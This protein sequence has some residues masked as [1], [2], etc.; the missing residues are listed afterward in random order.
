MYLKT[1]RCDPNRL[2]NAPF[3]FRVH[4][5]RRHTGVLGIP[6]KQMHIVHLTMSC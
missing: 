2:L 4:F 5:S 1:L 3:Y 6:A